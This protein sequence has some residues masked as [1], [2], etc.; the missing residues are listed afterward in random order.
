MPGR[1]LCKHLKASKTMQNA[2]T[3]DEHRTYETT[4]NKTLQN[5][6]QTP[7]A[8]VSSCSFGSS[9]GLPV[10]FSFLFLIHASEQTHKKMQVTYFSKTQRLLPIALL[11]F[12]SEKWTKTY[13]MQSAGYSLF[14]VFTLWNRKLFINCI[15][16]VLKEDFPC[17]RMNI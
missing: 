17:L 15:A 11:L 6:T 10:F 12:S 8:F 2:N 1:L 7:T 9:F 4:A 5:I 14:S 3:K 13:L 16:G